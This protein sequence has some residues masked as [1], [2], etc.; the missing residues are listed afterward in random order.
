M[1]ARISTGL[2]AVGGRAGR[3]FGLGTIVTIM[4]S[5]AL[6]AGAAQAQS[7]VTVDTGAR[8]PAISP[9]GSITLAVL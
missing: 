2:T 4:A 8:D 1:S 9:D 6:G 7:H 3:T 5:F